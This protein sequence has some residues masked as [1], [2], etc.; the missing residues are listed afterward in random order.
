MNSDSLTGYTRA[1]V[2][3]ILTTGVLVMLS[4]AIMF[5]WGSCPR[6]L[7]HWMAQP[8]LFASITGPAR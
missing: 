7:T 5:R 6:H 3:T 4:V 2:T 1:I 8:L